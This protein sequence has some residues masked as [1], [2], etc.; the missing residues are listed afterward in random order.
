M[1]REKD[2]QNSKSEKDLIVDLLKFS[3]EGFRKTPFS[4]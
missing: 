3:K 4:I 1:I 2:Q